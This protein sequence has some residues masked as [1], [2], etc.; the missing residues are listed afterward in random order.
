MRRFL[1]LSA[2]A[3]STAA[4]QTIAITGGTVFPVSGPKIDSGTVVITNG[5][6]TAV[7]KNVAIPAGAERIDATGKWVTPGFINGATS[8]GLSDAGSPQFS[9]GYNDTRATGTKG[10]AAS[11]NAWE[12]INPASVLF[13]PARQEG[14]T[15]AFVGPAGGL[16]GGRGAV[17]ELEDVLVVAIMQR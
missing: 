8:L 7:G 14:V 4:A 6:I 17:V 11:F 10:M 16:F 5:R 12:G 3:A 9:G 13:A 2:F 1:L 15:S